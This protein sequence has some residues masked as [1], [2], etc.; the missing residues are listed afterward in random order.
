MAFCRDC[1]D[2][3]KSSRDVDSIRRFTRCVWCETRHKEKTLKLIRARINARKIPAIARCRICQLPTRSPRANYCD[4][5]RL[6]I[7]RV[8][9]RVIPT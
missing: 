1:E 9:N 8:A 2:T 5:H 4:I 7:R 3:F 6:E